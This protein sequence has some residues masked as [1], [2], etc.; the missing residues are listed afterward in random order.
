M[1]KNIEIHS[2]RV[3]CYA[4]GNPEVAAVCHHCG[5]ALCDKHKAKSLPKYFGI[6]NN[7]FTDLGL[8]KKLVGENGIHCRDCNHLLFPYQWIRYLILFFIITNLVGTLILLYSENS[9]AR[10]IAWRG[11]L[12]LG[13]GVLLTAFLY[14]WARARYQQKLMTDRPL[15]PV[16]GRILSVAVR[17]FVGGE[18]TFDEEGN[19]K[20]SSR[21]PRE[22]GKLE[23]GM[24][25]S[26]RDRERIILYRRKFEIAANDPVKFHAGFVLLCG[27]ADLYF[28]NYR[29]AVAGQINTIELKERIEDH[30]FLGGGDAGGRAYWSVECPYTFAQKKR[31]TSHLLPVQIVPRLAREGEK[32]A[33]ELMVQVNPDI[34]I[35][36]L[37]N[38]DTC[39]KELVLYVPPKFGRVEQTRPLAS[40]SSISS[41]DIRNK[42]GVAGG[43]AVSWENV[44]VKKRTQDVRYQRFYVRFRNSIDRRMA[45]K[46]SGHLRVCFYTAFSG[47][48]GAS[49]FYPLGNRRRQEAIKLKRSTEVE[50]DFNL[51]LRGLCFQKTFLLKKER[52]EE[53]IIPDHHMI[54]QLTD[55][56]SNNDI[57]VQRVIENPPRTNKADARVLNRFWDITGRLYE[58]IY[59][60]D[61]HLVLIG[62]ERYKKTDQPVEGKTTFQIN[63]QATVIDEKTCQRVEGLMKELDVIIRE[64]LKNT[65]GIIE[66]N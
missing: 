3:R 34:E 48:E 29:R 36:D 50:L 32:W 21:I 17:E 24:K 12:F 18:I 30:L 5:R 26:P 65:S 23:I 44:Q 64:I 58:G 56:I 57:Y 39:V 1:S 25:F 60:V 53:G 43:R 7:E 8:N 49:L 35:P 42:N 46:V 45:D 31:K 13:L 55:A 15:L 27:A 28:D 38:V 9:L 59:P 22:P 62:Q 2:P 40:K 11:K 33:L 47:I 14:S 4:C 20:V 16:I 37:I 66:R 52:E 41:E 10:I 51:D 61:F 19:Y 63:V 54:K 6:K